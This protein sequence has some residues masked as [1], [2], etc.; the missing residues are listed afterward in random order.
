MQSWP[1]PPVPVLP[2][3]PGPLHLRDSARGLVAVA[4]EGTA[5]LYVCGITPVRRD[6]P[7]PRGDLP[8]VRHPRA[9][10]ARRRPGRAVRPERHRHRRPA[11]GARGAR[12]R[13]L[14]GRGGARDRAVP[15]GHD[16]AAGDRRRRT[17]SVRSRRWTRSP[18]PWP[19]C[20]RRAR[21]TGSTTTSTSRW[22]PPSTSAASRRCR[23]RSC[24]RS[25]PSGAATP[26]GRARRTRWTP[27]SGALSGPVSRPGSRRSAAVVPAGTWSARR[28]P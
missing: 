20:W 11:A 22:R 9:G 25:P 13:G 3:A 5:R 14:D 21:P 19:G 18:P 12:R 27:C 4:P 10:L 26:A 15:R 24:W 7:G 17:T 16:G 28:S 6:A 1:S 8:G 23:R 2:G